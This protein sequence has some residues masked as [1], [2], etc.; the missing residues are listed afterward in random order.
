MT[1]ELEENIKEILEDI[2]SGHSCH[3]YEIIKELVTQRKALSTKVREQEW[4]PIETAPMDGTPVDVYAANKEFPERY[5]DVR[6]RK[7][8]D[9]EFWVNGSDEPSDKDGTIGVEA[10]W[11]CDMIG[12][13]NGL[14]HWKPLTKPTQ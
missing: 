3:T 5:A 4:Q 6:W 2:E 10:R 8:S 13:L 9:S 12:A 7:P 14:T 11:Y 1:D